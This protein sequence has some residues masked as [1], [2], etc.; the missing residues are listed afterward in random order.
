M[1]G[2]GPSPRIP[3]V[4]LALDPGVRTSGWAVFRDGVVEASGLI[5]LKTR[6][7]LEPAVRV[8]HLLD[9]LSELAVR[10]GPGLAV[11]CRTGGINWTMPGLE[12]LEAG[13]QRWAGARGIPLASYTTQEVRS[14]VAGR[15]TASQDELGYA[16]MLRMGLIGQSRSTR[17]WS[18]IAVGCHHLSRS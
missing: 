6:Q 3:S 14:A 11:Q 16:V 10:W 7:K 13:L 9:A 12:E 1:T 4:L 17:E 15:S 8:G 18:A 5:G 2:P